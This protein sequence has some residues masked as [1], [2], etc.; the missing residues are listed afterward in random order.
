MTN[1][2]FHHFLD[3]NL[4]GDPCSLIPTK[5]QGFN[6][7]AS[8]KAALKE[9]EAFWINMATWLSWIDRKF[10]F[11]IGKNNYGRDEVTDNLVYSAAFYLFLEGYTPNVVAT[12]KPIFTGSFNNT[13]IPGLTISPPTITYDVGNAGANGNV[14]QRIRFE[15]QIQFTAASLAV[16][17]NPGNPPAPFTLDATISIAGKQLPL[18]AAEFFLLGGDDP[19]FTNINDTARNFS[20][21][22]QELRVFTIT[23]T[24]SAGAKIPH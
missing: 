12:S 16:F 1:S 5:Q 7:S 23:P 19:Y 9:I 17:P 10:Y 18:A 24:V 4:L 8:G 2:S 15:Y 13:N 14:I 3:L 21:L 22:S 11:V 20:Y 6:A